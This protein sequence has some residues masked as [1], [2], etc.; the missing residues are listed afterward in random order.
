MAT[1][2]ALG[3]AFACR[4]PALITGFPGHNCLVTHTFGGLIPVDFSVEI[5]CYRKV[6]RRRESPLAA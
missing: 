1:A 5:V 6:N 2:L 4:D 3:A